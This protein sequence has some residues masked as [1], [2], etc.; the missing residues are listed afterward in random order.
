MEGIK[1][2]RPR[3]IVPEFPHRGQLYK[4]VQLTWLIEERLEPAIPYEEAMEGY[5][6]LEGS[7]KFYAQHSLLELF[8]EQ[9]LKQ[10]QAYLLLAHDDREGL[11]EEVSL[12]IESRSFPLSG[13][14]VG[15]SS[16][17]YELYREPL[18]SLPF[19]VIGLFD[20]RGYEV[21]GPEELEEPS[22]E[23]QIAQAGSQRYAPPEGLEDLFPTEA[24]EAAL[25]ARPV[26]R[27]LGLT[28]EEEVL[29]EKLAAD[30][31][32]TVQPLLQAFIRD[33]ISSEPA[34]DASRREL[35]RHWLHR[36][37]PLRGSKKGWAYLWK[38][39]S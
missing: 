30:H 26:Y 6:R 32:F 3:T 18:Y 25:M 2:Y 35:A 13:Y 23:E 16:D 17:F 4:D 31:A 9:E 34:T 7:D 14:V 8:T 21:I 20:T 38:A 19:R 11:A 10:L 36:L 22:L 15:G 39:S 33:L 29:L 5:G 37:S 24:E 12:P 27:W 1:L 28:E